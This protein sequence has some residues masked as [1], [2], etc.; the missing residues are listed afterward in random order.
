MTWDR[1]RTG[2][3]LLGGASGLGRRVMA[4]SSAS[5]PPALLPAGKDGHS[6]TIWSYHLANIFHY[7]RVNVMLISDLHQARQWIPPL[8]PSQLALWKIFSQLHYIYQ[9]RD[10]GEGQNKRLKNTSEIKCKLTLSP[11]AGAHVIQSDRQL[12]ALITAY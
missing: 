12:P 5:E 6:S 7:L 8:A 4:L 1:G 9:V 3:P 10:W 11:H 2:W